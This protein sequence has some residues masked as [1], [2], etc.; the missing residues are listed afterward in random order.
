VKAIDTLSL[1]PIFI[2]APSS[3]RH[4][5]FNGRTPSADYLHAR[6]ETRGLKLNSTRRQ[7]ENAAAPACCGESGGR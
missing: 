3:T 5:L 2:K 1:P 6:G 7:F 4:Q